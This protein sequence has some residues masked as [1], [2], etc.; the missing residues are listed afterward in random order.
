MTPICKGASCSATVVGKMCG[1]R[2]ATSS[3]LGHYEEAGATLKQML[4]I[5]PLN[6]VGRANYAEWLSQNGRVEEAHRIADQLL[7]QHPG[8][9]YQAHAS[10][11]LTYEGKIAGGHDRRTGICSETWTTG[12]AVL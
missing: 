11:S 10:T 7:V 1:T 8:M 5:D 9:E 12:P 3:V 2:F 4:V 6:P